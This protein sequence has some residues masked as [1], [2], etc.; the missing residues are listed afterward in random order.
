MVPGSGAQAGA[1][2]FVAPHYIDQLG[3]DGLTSQEIAGSIGMENKN[4]L[5]LIERLIK[6]NDIDG[7]VTQRVD[8]TKHNALGGEYREVTYLVN[9]DD[10]KFIV[11]QSST[12]AGRAYCRYLI[13][14]EKAVLSLA[15]AAAAPALTLDTAMALANQAYQAL[16]FERAEKDRALAQAAYQDKA[17]TTSQVNNA[18]LTRKVITLEK[19]NHRLTLACAGQLEVMTIKQFNAAVGIMSNKNTN[20]LVAQLSNMCKERGL[21]VKKIIIGTEKWPSK[22]FQAAFLNEHIDL[23]RSYFK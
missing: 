1:G 7:R 9:V 17:L 13:E 22:A 3:C 18:K 8:I 19:D 20:Q 5:V 4:L 21:E 14:C 6:A 15:Q 10:A 2:A 12:K 16:L 11:T 23:I